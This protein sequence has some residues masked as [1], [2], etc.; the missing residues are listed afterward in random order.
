TEL[1]LTSFPGFYYIQL[2]PLPLLHD[3]RRRG[4]FSRWHCPSVRGPS[5]L[6][7]VTDRL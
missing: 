6:N 2:L 7:R 4:R 3:Y 5:G 1:R